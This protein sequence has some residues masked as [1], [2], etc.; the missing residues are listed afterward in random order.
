M[1]MKHT[2]MIRNAVLSDIEP[3]VGLLKQLFAIE[4]DF[5]F[6]AD[7]HRRGLRLLLDGCHKHK[8]IKVAEYDQRVVGMCSAQTLISS[9]E[10]GMVALVEDLVVDKKFRGRGIGAL[11]M[12]SIEAWRN[13]LGLKRLQ[14]L[15]D[16]QN[17][18]ALDFYKNNGWESTRLIC[19]RKTF[20]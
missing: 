14:L 11:L 13:T 1:E 17:R 18:P 15:A 6:D 10:G 7:K 19:I 20:G 8:C 4:A 9:A 2:V 3:M 12:K 16:C 5:I